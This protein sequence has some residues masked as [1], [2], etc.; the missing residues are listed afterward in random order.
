MA[1][2]ILCVLPSLSLPIAEELDSMQADLNGEEVK[3]TQV[4]AANL[5]NDLGEVHLPLHLRAL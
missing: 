2:A 4:P 5:Q 3:A 1:L